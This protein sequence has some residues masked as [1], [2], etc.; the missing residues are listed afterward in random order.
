[1]EKYKYE[2]TVLGTAILSQPLYEGLYNRGVKTLEGS[3]R[4]TDYYGIIRYSVERGFPGII[5]EHCFMS[6]PDEFEEFLSTDA[7]LRELALAD[8]TALAQ[9]YNLVR[10]VD[11][12]IRS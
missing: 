8:A 6:N 10:T 5:I 4:G 7:K 11:S 3:K 2:S 9:Y 12:G 1:M